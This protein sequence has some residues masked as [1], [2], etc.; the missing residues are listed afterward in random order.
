MNVSED[1]ALCYAKGKIGYIVLETVYT[2][3]SQCTFYAL[4]DKSLQCVKPVKISSRLTAISTGS[5]DPAQ[6]L[7]GDA[8][9][10]LG[11]QYM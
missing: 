6:N 10:G 7:I 4:S 11:L 8:T 1:I 3:I 9:A 5:V 2:Q